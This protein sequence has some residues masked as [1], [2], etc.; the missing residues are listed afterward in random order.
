MMAEKSIL[1]NHF[2]SEWYMNKK[3]KGGLSTTPDISKLVGLV[4]GILTILGCLVGVV[5]YINTLRNDIDYLTDK[6]DAQNTQISSLESSFREEI[7]QVS[8]DMDSFSDDMSSVKEIITALSVKVFDY[9]PTVFF[10]SA[11]TSTY[12]GVDAPYSSESPQI[13]AMSY[14][15]YSASNPEREYTAAEVAEQPLLLPYTENGNEVYFYGQLDSAGNWDGRCIVNIYDGNVLQLITDAMY[16]GGTL[17]SCKQAFPDTVTSGEDVWVI[18]ERKVEDGFSTGETYRY[19]R[20]DDYTKSFS[21]DNVE[22]DDI[23]NVDEFSAQITSTLEGYYCGEIS[24]GQYN[25]DSGD[26]YFVKFFQDG[27]VRTLYVGNFKDGQFN[28]Q[29]GTAWMIGKLEIGASYSFYQGPFKNSVSSRDSC[30]W[31]EPIS[32]DRIQEILKEFGFTSAVN[33][34]WT[35]GSSI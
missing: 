21:L 11:I 26:A 20:S 5:R 22:P 19:F 16:D 25:D 1:W 3:K 33:L 30:Y 12:D 10:A 24:D 28:D 4:A 27:T 14:V 2:G 31:E 17:L 29:T 23:L 32:T 13:S 18:S 15:V 7:Q 6:I 8:Q 35:A 34:N 9:R